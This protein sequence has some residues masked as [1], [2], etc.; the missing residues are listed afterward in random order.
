M[1]AVMGY[2]ITLALGHGRHWKKNLASAEDRQETD[3][4]RR[5]PVEYFLD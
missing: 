5:S 3:G 4:K 2:G 1:S